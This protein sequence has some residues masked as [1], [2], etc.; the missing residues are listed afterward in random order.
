MYNEIFYG[1]LIQRHAGSDE[2]LGIKFHWPGYTI[3]G[4]H[5]Y[6]LSLNLT[7]VKRRDFKTSGISTSDFYVYLLMLW[8]RALQVCT[9]CLNQ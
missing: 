1:K 2:K 4:L 5:F 3:A 7:E 6:P 9:S 8:A